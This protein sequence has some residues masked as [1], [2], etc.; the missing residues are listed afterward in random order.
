MQRQ[1]EEALDTAV[2]FGKY[3]GRTVRSVLL[4]AKWKQ[5]GKVDQGWL[6]YLQ[7]QKYVPV[8]VYTR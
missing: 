6:A 8:L 5:S 4:E 3:K 1:I 7:Q 2:P